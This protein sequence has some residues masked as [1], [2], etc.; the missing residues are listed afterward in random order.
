METEPAL[1]RGT[2]LAHPKGPT[3]LTLGDVPNA[4]KAPH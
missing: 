3:S 4:Q 2:Y 1:T